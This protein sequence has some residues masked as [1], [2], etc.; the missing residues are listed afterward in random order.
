MHRL[1]VFLPFTL[2]G[3]LSAQEPTVVGSL[4]HVS[5]RYPATWELIVESDS[6]ASQPACI[7]S[8]RPKDSVEEHTLDGYS[9]RLAVSELSVDEALQMA[10]F[11]QEGSRWFVTGAA[12][13][14]SAS[15][16]SGPGWR[17]A[18]G[19]TV[20]RCF[21]QGGDG[22]GGLCDTPFA[23]LGTPR[24]SVTIQGG[25]ASGEIVGALLAT[26]RFEP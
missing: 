24:R 10:F 20:F 18:Y 8:L 3:V 7:A 13:R 9:I 21:P 25:E 17:G 2:V 5:I 12:G 11:E 4:C 26:V 1:L 16:I 14:D 15:A 23:V 22:P 19:I 6:T